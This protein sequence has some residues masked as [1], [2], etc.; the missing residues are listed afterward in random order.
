[1]RLFSLDEGKWRLEVSNNGHE[2]SEEAFEKLGRSIDSVKPEGLGMG[3]SIVRGIVDSHGALLH[4]T[5][6]E[7]GG[8]VVQCTIDKLP[9]NAPSE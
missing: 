1:M 9:E 3:L 8:L 4:F 6:R 2:L 7:G 5:R